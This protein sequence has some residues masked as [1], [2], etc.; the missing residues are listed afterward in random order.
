MSEYTEKT[1]TKWETHIRTVS[2]GLVILLLSGIY[3]KLNTLG[4]G[5]A[6]VTK[7]VAVVNVRLEQVADI[8]HAQDRFRVELKDQGERIT[9]LEYQFYNNKE[10]PDG[11]K[12][13]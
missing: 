11:R 3:T 8:K 6:D 7:E 12:K 13:D 2:S 10:K 4:D 1:V 5:L 9:L